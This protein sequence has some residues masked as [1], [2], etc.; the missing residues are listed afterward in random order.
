VSPSE[1]E[2]TTRKKRPWNGRDFYISFGDGDS[3]R[4]E[5]ARTYGFGSGGGDPW[6]S[7]S[8]NALQPTNRV[9]VHIPQRGYV[10]VGKVIES[11]QP[12]SEFK[13]SLDSVQVPI[14]E[15]PDL[16]TP[17]IGHDLGDPDKCE[18][19]VRVDWDKTHGREHA[20]WEA[21]LFANQNT[22]AKLRDTHTI[23]RL[24]Q[25]FGLDPGGDE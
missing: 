9:F 4:W 24:E 17:A 8:L 16:Q 25:H 1:A 18:Y 12:V 2:A 21:G 20:W 6:F 10:G 7:R 23:A 11:A 15:A 13:I 3:R 5:D 14:L 22:A 19:L